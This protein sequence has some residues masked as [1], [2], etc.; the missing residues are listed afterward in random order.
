MAIYLTA[1]AAGVAVIAV[2]VYL[3]VKPTVY[4]NPPI[5]RANPLLNGPVIGARDTSRAP[6]ALLKRRV[7]VDPKIVAAL[8]AKVKQPERRRASSPQVAQQP[9][10]RPRGQAVAEVREQSPRGPSFFQMLFGG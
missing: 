7:I 1:L 10:Q 3:A 2:P 5:V 8:N 6:L 4:D 9:T